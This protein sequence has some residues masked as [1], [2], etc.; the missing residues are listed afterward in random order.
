MVADGDQ[1][2]FAVGGV[3][4]AGGIG[5]DERGAA[6]QAEDSRGEG[7]LSHGI[8][9]IGVHAALHY[10]HVDAADA[11][12]DELAAVAEDGG[13][14]PVGDLGVVD[15]GGL[16]HVRGEVAQAGAED[17][18]ERGRRGVPRANVLGCGEGAGVLVGAVLR[19]GHPLHRNRGLVRGSAHEQQFPPFVACAQGRGYTRG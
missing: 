18:A 1:R 5:D 6:E 4:A 13:E 9:F 15:G 12:E 8:A 2:A 3:D 7:H 16:L 11:A 19:D 10:R 17:D 14:R